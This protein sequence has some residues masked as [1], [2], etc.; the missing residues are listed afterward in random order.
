[1][2]NTANILK[3]ADSV[4]VLFKSPTLSDRTSCICDVA[5]KQHKEAGSKNL[6]SHLQA[7]HSGVVNHSYHTTESDLACDRLRG[8]VGD[9]CVTAL[10]S[11]ALLSPD[12]LLELGA[13]PSS[14]AIR[15]FSSAS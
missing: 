4:R 12:A 6:I 10:V 1:M 3:N 11:A 7:H 2:K 13:G 9:T 5:V 15:S 14:D 8:V